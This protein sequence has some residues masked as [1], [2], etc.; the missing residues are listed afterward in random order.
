MFTIPTRAT[1]LI[2][3]LSKDSTHLLS[4]IRAMGLIMRSIAASDITSNLLLAD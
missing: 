4:N 2:G 1:I 3:P